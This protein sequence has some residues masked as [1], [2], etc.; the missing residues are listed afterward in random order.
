MDGESRY[1]HEQCF[2][3]FPRLMD[4]DV[5]KVMSSKP[6]I[7]VKPAIFFPSFDKKRD[8]NENIPKALCYLRDVFEEPSQT[9]ALIKDHRSH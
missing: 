2:C 7:Q 4:Y 6:K 9:P 1:S 8:R 5:F 3:M